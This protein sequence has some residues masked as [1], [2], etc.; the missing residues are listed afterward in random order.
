MNTIKIPSEEDILKNLKHS[1]ILRAYKDCPHLLERF[2]CM[3]IQEGSLATCRCGCKTFKITTG[4][5]Y[6][7]EQRIECRVR[8]TN[9]LGDAVHMNCYPFFTGPDL[10]KEE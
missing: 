5:S 1:T 6:M 7:I 10:L 9:D 3:S 4:K 2:I 8:I